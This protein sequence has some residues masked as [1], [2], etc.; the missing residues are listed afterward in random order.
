VRHLNDSWGKNIQH[1]VRRKGWS[2]GQEALKHSG[3][4]GKPCQP[5]PGTGEGWQGRQ[6]KKVPGKVRTSTVTLHHPYIR[7][8]SK[9]PHASASEPTTS[10]I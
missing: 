1:K 6:E 3:A 5:P 4:D 7:I 10:L 9:K 8:Q 2:K